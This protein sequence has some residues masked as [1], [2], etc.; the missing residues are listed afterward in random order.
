M[1]FDG[2]VGAAQAMYLGYESA[3]MSWAALPLAQFLPLWFQLRDCVQSELLKRRGYLCHELHPH[4]WFARMAERDDVSMFAAVPNDV[5]PPPVKVV[6]ALLD[7]GAAQCL[8]L[9]AA[10]RGWTGN[11]GT[12]VMRKDA[13]GDMNFSE[14]ARRGNAAMLA[15]L[16]DNGL[17][18]STATAVA[19][20]EAGQLAVLKVLRERST[21][22]KRRPSA[23]WED[24]AVVLAAAS[25]GHEKCLRF[26]LEHGGRSASCVWDAKRA[27]AR[28]G[29]VNCMRVLFAAAAGGSVEPPNAMLRLGCL[30]AVRD[31]VDC[32]R[33]LVGELGAPA[34]SDMCL[35]AATSG[36][37]NCLAYLINDRGAAWDVDACR[38]SAS[39]SGHGALVGEWIDEWL[40]RR[41]SQL[42]MVAAP[43]ATMMQPSPPP[44]SQLY[45]QPPFMFVQAA[46]PPP[47]QYLQTVLPQTYAS[48]DVRPPPPVAARAPSDQPSETERRLTALLR[49]QQDLVRG[50]SHLISPRD[51][52]RL[53]HDA[54]DRYDDS[55]DRRRYDDDCW[56]NNRYDDNRFDDDR[57]RPHPRDACDDRRFPRDVYAR[58]PSAAPPRLLNRPRSRARCDYDDYEEDDYAYSSRRPRF[59]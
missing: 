41:R 46:P 52:R 20:A 7:P 50:F 43:S 55:Y 54:R 4:K 53:P 36:A 16:L 6:K 1:L 31:H 38:A 18:V 59:V 39:S 3:Q 13:R 12:I 32:L 19:A 8:A 34:H 22:A 58:F 42:Q 17:Y 47:Q 49:E 2:G 30:A 28:G 15:L 14:G 29:H 56:D 23:G 37:L 48:Y 44:Q 51:D 25:A 10:R 24:A 21:P 26:A 40:Q 9:W 45:Q 35:C 33:L 57:R 5:L 27:A 11:W